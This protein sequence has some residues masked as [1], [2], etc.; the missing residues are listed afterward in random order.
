[1]TEKLGLFTEIEQ[2]DLIPTNEFLR[3][4]PDAEVRV[5]LK[6]LI[7]A[8]K[9]DPT[10]TLVSY[11]SRFNS[12]N[13]LYAISICIREGAD[14]NTYTS[15]DGITG[16]MHL[17]IYAYVHLE[18]TDLFRDL[19]LLLIASGSSPNKQ[20]FRNNGIRETATGETVLEYLR[21]KG[22]D[23]FL[24]QDTSKYITKKIKILAG[25]AD[26]VF[27][28]DDAL[29]AIKCHSNMVSYPEPEKA[30]DS[31]LIIESVFNFDRDTAR[32]Y[33]ANGRNLS[34]PLVNTILIN[35][36]A[37]ISVN[38]LRTRLG[39]ILGDA[40]DH[41]LELDSDQ[42][43][44]LAASGE[45]LYR[46]IMEKYT[47]PH[48]K[49]HCRSTSKFND[50]ISPKLISSVMSLGFASSKESMCS[51]LNNIFLSNSKDI[52]QALTNRQ[53]ARVG[54]KFGH[55]HE[56]LTL[57]PPVLQV[58]NLQDAYSYVDDYIVFFR[59]E[60]SRLWAWTSDN[61]EFLL[62]SK[63]N[64]STSGALP[65]SLLNEIARKP[66]SKKPL[67]WEDLISTI[68]NPDTIDNRQTEIEIKLMNDSIG[69]SLSKLT[70]VDFSRIVQSIGYD[71]S[72]DLLTDSHAMST[73][74]YIY[75][76][77]ALNHPTTADSLV[78]NIRMLTL[79]INKHIF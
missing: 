16:H 55:I 36:S 17:I 72:L 37:L 56:F 42:Q 34:Y 59:D 75:N 3:L 49:K 24:N 78:R 51:F 61:F 9:L 20:A 68:M 22:L 52:I 71:Y 31:V 40:V 63:I 5:M 21:S 12:V 8:G 1:M 62:K 14:V 50:E 35:L 15:S 7:R 53:K 23:A 13:L 69:I 30:L 28:I 44:M 33:I 6:T 64:P 60:N 58:E 39:W 70:A 74:A 47:I 19:I 32:Y 73:F 54:S 41:G 11:I 43:A 18:Q 67:K 66:K 4:T 77:Y 57:T 76:Y 10:E 29:L 25:T 26:T 46:Y 38:T 27:T 45:D 2:N 48:W 79:P 65:E